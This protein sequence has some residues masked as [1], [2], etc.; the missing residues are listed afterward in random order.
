MW[1]GTMY[2]GKM[3]EARE[4]KLKRHLQNKSSVKL[5]NTSAQSIISI[6]NDIRTG[7]CMV[8]DWVVGLEYMVRNIDLL[9]TFG[10]ED[11]LTDEAPTKP[12][13]IERLKQIVDE[14]DKKTKKEVDDEFFDN[15]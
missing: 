9:E 13:S 5:S 14:T 3:S 15:L 1:R 8:T 10:C 2:Q 11:F 12:I 6:V 7:V 4:A